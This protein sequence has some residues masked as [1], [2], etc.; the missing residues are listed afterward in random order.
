[1]AG[2]YLTGEEI[3]K[4]YDLTGR[5][6]LIIGAN[7]GLGKETARVLALRNCRGQGQSRRELMQSSKY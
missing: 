2:K 5:I 1:M 3:S 4:S 7:D 6:A